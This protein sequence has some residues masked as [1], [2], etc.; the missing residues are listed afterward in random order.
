MTAPP[1]TPEGRTKALR[2]E[3]VDGEWECSDWFEIVDAPPGGLHHGS[4]GSIPADTVVIV[5]GEERVA[6]ADAINVEPTNLYAWD[7][8]YYLVLRAREVLSPET[9]RTL[10]WRDLGPG[11]VL[12]VWDKFHGIAALRG[13]HDPTRSLSYGGDFAHLEDLVNRLRPPARLPERS[14]PPGADQLLSAVRDDDL[15]R[16]KQLLA[17]GVD[18]RDLGAPDGVRCLELEVSVARTTSPLWESI[19]GASPAVTEALLAAGA[20]L[21][22]RGD[23][24]PALHVA[25]V[26][27]RPEHVRVLLRFGADPGAAHRGKS[28]QELA[29]AISPEL[30]ALLRGRGAG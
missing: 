14:D 16:V 2:L 15:A 27:R 22:G 24:M 23:E 20:P 1:D 11:N 21:E 19:Q 26:A 13:Q 10:P 18:P 25:L 30:G 8:E 17:R 28:A 3:L 29:D 12:H 4:R 7:N 6:L 5:L 9:W